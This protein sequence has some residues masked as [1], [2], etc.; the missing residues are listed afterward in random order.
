MSA[1]DDLLQ[2]MADEELVLAKAL[3][4][5][6]DADDDGDG[7]IADMADD[8]D[9]D[10]EPDGDEDGEDDDDDGD[11]MM[12]SLEVTL[13]DG[14]VVEALDGTSLV[15]SLVAKNEDLTANVTSLAG[16][17]V[18]LLKSMS[19]TV[20]KQAAQIA[21]L[22]KSLSKLSATG[23]GRRSK[24]AVHDRQ[25]DPIGEL[26]E[27]NAGEQIMAKA[28][29]AFDAGRITGIELNTVDVS[30]RTNQV[31]PTDLLKKIA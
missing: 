2:Q 28:M 27:G 29:K 24:V 5:K 31:P 20:T 21:D 14:R 19:A 25:S 11:G 30:L 8:E 15:K 22:Q 1:F 9:D 13:P 4:A 17:T 26:P 23:T 3:E 6:P 10:G 16:Q 7:K 12:K 18:T